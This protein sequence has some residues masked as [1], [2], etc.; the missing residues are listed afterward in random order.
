MWAA[1]PSRWK[2]FRHRRQCLI[3]RI[4]GPSCSPSPLVMYSVFANS[5]RWRHSGHAWLVR[6]S[7]RRTRECAASLVLRDKASNNFASMDAWWPFLVPC[8]KP[9]IP[10]PTSSFCSAL[11]LAGGT[12]ARI[13]LERPSSAERI[14]RDTPH[15]FL[16]T[17]FA[18]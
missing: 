5:P 14:E 7:S 3:L 1:N 13:R 4:R 2:Y 10:M 17:V 6:Y 16:L 8:E 11:L 12:E 9:S 15:D 18:L